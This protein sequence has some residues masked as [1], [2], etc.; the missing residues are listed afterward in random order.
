MP[1]LAS[2]PIVRRALALA[3]RHPEWATLEVLDAAMDGFTN[4]HPDFEVEP[5]EGFSDWLEPPSPFAALLRRAFGA[6]LDDADCAAESDKWQE[7]IEA[8]G[9][10]YRLWR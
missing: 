4:T 3:E 9:D 2:N 6:H 5:A 7:V 10:R 1:G 8:F